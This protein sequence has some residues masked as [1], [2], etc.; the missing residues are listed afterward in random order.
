MNEPSPDATHLYLIRHG[1]TDANLQRPYVLQGQGIDHELSE[2]GRQ[3]AAAVAEF[4]ATMTVQ[5]VYSSGMKRA[6]ETAEMIAEQ[7]RLSVDKIDALAEVD[8]G[9]WEG[10]DWDSIMREFPA[11]YRDFMDD[12]GENPYLGG[13]S[14]ADVLRRI[15]PPLQQLL[16][17]HPGQTIVVVAHN[18]VNR[19]YLSE[20]LGIELRKA[21]DIRQTNTGINVIR[22]RR[23][24]TELLTLNA[25]FHLANLPAV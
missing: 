19:V 14:Y 20:L 8:V 5:N 18:V 13:E 7:H 17:D 22:Y 25:H 3:Q 6:V 10:R 2:T 23:G 16:R 4:L 15:R 12:P 9:V 24:E 21:K 1:A 11:A